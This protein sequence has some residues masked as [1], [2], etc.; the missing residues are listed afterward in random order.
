MKLMKNLSKREEIFLIYNG[1][2]E[3]IRPLFTRFTLLQKLY[4]S[5]LC[6]F[7]KYQIFHLAFSPLIPLIS[8]G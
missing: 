3:R 1:T 4:N 6:P 8:T 7:K 2:D 5:L